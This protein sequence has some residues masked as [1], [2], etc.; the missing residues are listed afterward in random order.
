MAGQRETRKAAAGK[1]GEA[2]LTMSGKTSGTIVNEKRWLR[3]ECA[4][5]GGKKM[6]AHD[7]TDSPFFFSLASLHSLLSPPADIC[8]RNRRLFVKIDLL[9]TP[10]TL[11]RLFGLPLPLD[12]AE[13]NDETVLVASPRPAAL[14]AAQDHYRD[15]HTTQRKLAAFRAQP[16]LD[17]L[18]LDPPL[19]TL[20]PAKDGRRSSPL[21]SST[22]K[23]HSTPDVVSTDGRG[24]TADLETSEPG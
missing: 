2:R 13:K 1:L 20:A 8:K 15:A 23:C 18:L 21:K 22:R 12:L 9:Q 3:V 14:S 5:A 6:R 11:H 4:A 17:L 19:L 10:T 7:E 16:P 24:R